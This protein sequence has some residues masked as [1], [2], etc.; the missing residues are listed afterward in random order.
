MKPDVIV[1]GAGSG[2]G[3]VASRLTE[4]P[5]VNVLLLEAGPDTWPDVPDEVKHVRGGSG[6]EEYDW[7]Y[8]DPS[9]GAVLP[10]GRLVGGSSAINASYALRGQPVDYDGWGRGWSWS[11]CLP[12]FNR[13]ED[14]ADFGDSPYHGRGGTVHRSRPPPHPSR[15]GSFIRARPVL[16]H[17]TIAQRSS[18]C[19]LGRR[20]LRTP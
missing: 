15:L 9:I 14:D 4:D 13:L 12:Y 8:G 6:V 2:G 17:Q 3:V 11:E 16:A 19:R 1:V 5:K 20:P 10:R 7:H 18:L